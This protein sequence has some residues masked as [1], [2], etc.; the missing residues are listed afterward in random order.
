VNYYEHHLGDYAAATAHLS[1]DEDMA[2][3]RLIRAYYHHEKPLPADVKDV[4][5][6]VRAASS[7]QKK[8]VD[9]VLREFFELKE[10]GWHQKRCDEEVARYQDK[11][12]K[13]QRSA[14]ARWHAKRSDSEGN[15]NASRSDDANALPT[16]CEGNAPSLQSP[17]SSP[18]LQTPVSRDGER[19]RGVRLPI[20]WVLTPERR[21]IAEAEN[22][23]P[24]RTFAKFTA[25][26]QAAS[27]RTATKRS[28]DAAWRYWCREERDRRPKN[29]SS[30]HQPQAP[31][32]Y[33]T[34]DEIEAEERARGDYDAQH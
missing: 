21:G 6:L 5:R 30:S 23:D 3:T 13:A 10:D 34:A 26:W 20:D 19:A 15:A 18:N 27:G 7:V 16:Q 29:G 24:E 4:C 31:I 12:S 9:T 1:W 32:V 33:R 28:W 17:V 11:R 25:Y 2:Y 8:S 14:D 22:L